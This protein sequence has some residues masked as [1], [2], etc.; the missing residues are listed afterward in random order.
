V[1]FRSR[2]SGNQTISGDKTFSAVPFISAATGNLTFANSSLT[3]RGILGTVGDNDQWFFGGGATASNAGF[4]EIA[5]GD[6]GTEP[7]YVSQYQP[8]NPVT[9]TLLRR[10]TLLDPSGNTSFP[11]TITATS[12]VG[13]LSGN[14][15]TATTAS[16][17]N[18]VGGLA[19]HAGTNNEANKI[20]RTQANGYIMAGWINTISGD[21]GTT[22]PTRIYASSD[23]Y[24]RYYSVA[25]FRQ[26]IDVPTRTGGSASGTWGINITGSSASTTGNAATATALQTARTI[27]GVSFNGTTNITLP[28]VNTSGNQTTIAGAKT[29]TGNVRVASFGVNTNASGTAGEIRATNNITA[30]FSDDRL[31]TRVKNIEEALEKISTLDAFYYIPNKTAIDLGYEEEQ[32]IGLSAQQV[33]KIFPEVV[34]PAPIDDKYLTIQY[35][36]LIPLLVAGI[37]ELKEEVSS[38]KKIILRDE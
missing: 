15:T 9:G 20:V 14:A 21:N 30:F 38:L 34:R 33:N 23:G 4:L 36:K 37:K 17:S 26:V 13:S 2:T 27:N 6:D 32:H 7:I 16:N 10:A 22:T 8:G 3:K 1:L 11:G 35:D 29:F 12:F 28:T 19:V 24:I 5:T 18:A 31:K 25:N